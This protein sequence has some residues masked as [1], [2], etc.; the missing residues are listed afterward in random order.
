M[1]PMVNVYIYTFLFIPISIYLFYVII[2]SVRKTDSGIKCILL[3]LQVSL[4]GG[5]LVVDSNI[6]L[7][8]FEYLFVLLGLILSFIGIRKN[9]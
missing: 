3:G 4:V 7:R 6:D 1:S 9:N 2:V 5:I 8:G